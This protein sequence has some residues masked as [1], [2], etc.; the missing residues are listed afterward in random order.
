MIVLLTIGLTVLAATLEGFALT[1]LWG[2]F[3]VPAFGVPAL[4]I[5]YAIGLALVVGMLTHRV[6]SDNDKPDTVTVLA[7]GLVMPFV[8]IAIGWIVRLFV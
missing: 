6:R 2:W 1:V 3:I 4:R 7:H 8:Y 5:P